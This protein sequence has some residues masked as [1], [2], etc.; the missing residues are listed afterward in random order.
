GGDPAEV[1]CG[2]LAASVGVSHTCTRRCYT[3]AWTA[4]VTLTREEEQHASDGAKRSDWVVDCGDLRR[5]GDGLQ[6]PAEVRRGAHYR[7]QGDARRLFGHGPR[8]P[9]A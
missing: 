6:R 4:I 5:R 2:F 1:R 3:R 9:V 8:P 7:A